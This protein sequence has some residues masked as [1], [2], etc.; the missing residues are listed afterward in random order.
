MDFRFTAKEYQHKEK[1]NGQSRPAGHKL[2]HSHT[3]L[4]RF[5]LAGRVYFQVSCREN[6]VSR[7][8]RFLSLSSINDFLFLCNHSVDEECLAVLMELS[9][10]IKSDRN[11]DNFRFHPH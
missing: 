8:I 7:Q 4:H 11:N 2:D 9:V 5:L 1:L 10:E 6:A 3:H